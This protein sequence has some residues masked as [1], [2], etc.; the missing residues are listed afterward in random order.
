MQN[1]GYGAYVFFAVFCL[2]SLIWTYLFVPETAHRTLEQMDL[3][4]KD[5]TGER[6]EDRGKKIE[7]EII[8]RRASSTEGTPLV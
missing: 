2:L 5:S 1:T 6:E 8:V 3:M 4:F 7:S